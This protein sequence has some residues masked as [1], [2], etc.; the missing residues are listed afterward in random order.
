MIRRLFSRRNTEQDPEPSPGTPDPALEEHLHAVVHHAL[1][2]WAVVHPQWAEDGALRR[3]KATFERQFVN[4]LVGN[5]RLRRQT[6]KLLQDAI[7]IPGHG[8]W[9]LCWDMDNRTL[10][11]EAAALPTHAVN[12]APASISADTLDDLRPPQIP[13]GVDEHGDPVIWP[14]DRIVSAL[15][16]DGVGCSGTSTQIRTIILGAA[17]AAMCVVIANFS[18]RTD[19]FDGLRDW[20]NIHLVANGGKKG[21]RAV[22]YVHQIFASRRL[23]GRRGTPILLVINGFDEL[24]AM[25]QGNHRSLPLGAETSLVIERKLLQL[26]RLG[27]AAGI[28]LLVETGTVPHE[29]DIHNLAFRIQVGY[30]AGKV[31]YRLWEDLLVG[32]TVPLNTPGRSL[33]HGDDGYHQFQGYYTPDPADPN[34]SDEDTQILA[35]LRPEHARHPRMVIDMP[36]AATEWDLIDSAPVVP[37]ETR[38][39]LDP[40]SDQYRPDSDDPPA[41]SPIR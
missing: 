19:E 11:A 18:H 15:I 1:G 24:N 7:P 13:C 29:I 8:W 33:T 27:L 23:T 28:H 25:L 16:V 40:L 26:R 5:P 12:P 32:Q 34:L 9:N 3:Y 39:D 6:E 37:A 10:L 22:S 2:P 14:L 36:A 31:S 4:D 20:P 30:L 21:L 35:A 38:P 17:K 41:D